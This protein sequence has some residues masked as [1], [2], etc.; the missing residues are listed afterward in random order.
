MKTKKQLTEEL[1]A[2][3][4]AVPAN[5]NLPTLQDLAKANGIAIEEKPPESTDPAVAPPAPYDPG[6]IITP[7]M[8]VVGM[9]GHRA[10]IPDAAVDSH[11]EA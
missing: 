1:T 10:E 8:A 9:S 11:P 5:A 2:A 7:V 3:G 4:V 6:R